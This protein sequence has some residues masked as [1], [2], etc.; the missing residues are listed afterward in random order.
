MTESRY[1][2]GGRVR[3]LLELGYESL[4]ELDPR[5]AVFPE[6]EDV[7]ERGIVVCLDLE[8]R[9]R[10]VLLR[11]TFGLV[12]DARARIDAGGTVGAGALGEPVVR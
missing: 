5:M 7:D 8:G 2:I 4:G 10:G 9:P 1:L 6:L 11:N 12:T 3:R